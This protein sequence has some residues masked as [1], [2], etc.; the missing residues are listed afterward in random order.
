MRGMRQT[1]TLATVALMGLSVAFAG[2]GGGSQATPMTPI[3][4]SVSIV[5]QYNLVLTSTNGQGTTNIYTNFTQTGTTFTGAANT[6]VCALNDSSQCQGGDPS[7]IAI[8]PSATVSGANV[9]I[10]I[11]FP[12]T[13]GAHTVTMVGTMTAT[14]LNGTYIDSLG[15]SGTWTASTAIYPLGP[16]P[17]VND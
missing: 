12:G 8:T 15:D 14:A 7:V 6:L 16:P 17:G 10:E 5:G 1:T 9:T 4:P 2:C 13:V 3:T 11:S